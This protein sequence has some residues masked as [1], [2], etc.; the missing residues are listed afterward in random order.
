M[1][2][3]LKFVSMFSEQ[4]PPTLQNHWLFTEDPRGPCALPP[5]DQGTHTATHKGH[6]MLPGAPGGGSALIVSCRLGPSV[7]LGDLPVRVFPVSV[8][9]HP[10][11]PLAFDVLAD[12]PPPPFCLGQC[13]SDQGVLPKERE[14][15]SVTT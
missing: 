9:Y 2:V 11:I 13:N 14:L 3:C 10:P 6:H 1:T 15:L 8:S 7:A 4:K 12:L 5:Q